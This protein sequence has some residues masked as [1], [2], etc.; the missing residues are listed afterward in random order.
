MN[1]IE[2]DY[3]IEDMDECF[4]FALRGELDAVEE[5]DRTFIEMKW[6]SLIFL[7]LFI[8]LEES[9]G[10]SD[11]GGEEGIIAEVQERLTSFL[12]L[13]HGN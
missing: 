9:E 12:R 13:C 10:G 3:K 7:R 6:N 11:S 4:G 8:K 2:D 5:D 1:I